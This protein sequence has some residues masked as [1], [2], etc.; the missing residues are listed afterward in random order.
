MSLLLSVSLSKVSPLGLLVVLRFAC[1]EGGEEV[2]AV[3]DVRLRLS[4]CTKPCRALSL[5]ICEL[6]VVAWSYGAKM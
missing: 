2:L 1:R 6:I 5:D 3:L 4:R